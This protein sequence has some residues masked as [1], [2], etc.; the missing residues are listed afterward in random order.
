M[1]RITPCL[2]APIPVPLNIE[3]MSITLKVLE[4]RLR[5]DKHDESNTGLFSHFSLHNS[6]KHNLVKM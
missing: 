3:D 1:I 6:P 2:G 4:M 5:A